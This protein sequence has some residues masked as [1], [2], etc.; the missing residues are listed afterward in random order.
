M[1]RI[2]KTDIQPL[3]NEGASIEDLA[4]SIF[5]AVVNQTISGLACRHPIK[6]K[7]AFLGGP[8]SFLSEL[9]ARFTET[10][11]LAAE[12]IIFPENSKYFVAIGA[13]LLSEKYGE[14]TLGA[15]VNALDN[16]DASEV[17]DT[18]HI[19]PLFESEADYAEFTA[20][21]AADKVKTGELAKA[22][23]RLYLGIDAGSTT[24][25]SALI[26]EEQQS[27]LLILQKQRG[28]ASFETDS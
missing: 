8:L 2:C 22:S 21:H 15:I 24:T 17:S 9:R 18:K 23:G 27:A 3:I 6:G 10:L 14:T 16:I 26:D 20:R 28:Q 1:R 12:D 13:A 4:A 25:K 19:E 11:G 5:Q 7:V